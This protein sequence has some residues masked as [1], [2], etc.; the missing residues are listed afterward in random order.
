MR[1]SD[2]KN[3]EALDVLAE[4]LEPAAIIVADKELVKLAGNAKTRIKAASYALKEHKKEV[5]AIIA[6]LHRQEPEEL[7]FSVASIGIE[8]LDIFNDPAL[9]EVFLSQ[10]Q[11]TSSESFG[12]A[13]ATTGESEE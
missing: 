10:G 11:M 7:E 12:S 5:I 1:L 6:A 8:L 3:E 4:I 2:Y 13:T 9:Q